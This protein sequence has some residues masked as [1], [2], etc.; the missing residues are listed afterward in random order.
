MNRFLLLLAALFAV[1]AVAH[2]RVCEEDKDMKGYYLSCK[3]D[4]TREMIWY[5]DDREC[6]SSGL[7]TRDRETGL[8]CNIDCAAGEYLPWAGTACQTCP[9]GSFSVGGGARFD[10]FDSWPHERSVIFRSWCARPSSYDD[11][12]NHEI[13]DGWRLSGYY[14]DSGDLKDYNSVSSVLVASF[15]LSE[16]DSYVRF[17]YSL[18]TEKGSDGL[19]I[20][21]DN[22]APREL[23]PTAE[24][25]EVTLYFTSGLHFVSWVYYKD[26]AGSFGED[27]AKLD[28]IEIYGLRLSD[29]E[30]TPCTPGFYGEHPGM[31]MCEE[32]SFNEF[33]SQH[34]STMCTACPDDQYALKG[35]F[36]CEDRTE[37]CEDDD[38]DF[39]YTECHQDASGNWVREKEAAWIQPDFCLHDGAVS[40][41]TSQTGLTCASCKPGYH[42][43]GAEGT[44]ELCPVGH[45]A[46][47]EEICNACPEGT[48]AVPEVYYDEWDEWLPKWSTGCI[49]EDCNTDGWELYSEHIH[50]GHHQGQRVDVWA[51]L[52]VNIQSFGGAVEFTYKLEGGSRY[53]FLQFLIDGYYG[54]IIRQMSETFYTERFELE[55]G[56]HELVWNFHRLDNAN[57]YPDARAYLQKVVVYGME[58]GGAGDCTTCPAGFYQDQPEQPE[59]KACAPGSANSDEGSTSCKKCSGREFARSDG[60]K[61]CLPCGVG[62][63]PN[64][65]HSDCVTD[66]VFMNKEKDVFDL[67]ALSNIHTVTGLRND[68][69]FIFDFCGRLPN[70]KCG[71]TNPYVC[72]EREV[73]T[74]RGEVLDFQYDSGSFLEFRSAEKS[75]YAFELAYTN[76][77]YEDC[78]VEVDRETLIKFKCNT[79]NT[80]STI[81]ILPKESDHCKN[82]F[83]VLSPY[84]C[85]VCTIDDFDR[86]E[87]SCSGGSRTVSFTKKSDAICYGS[88]QDDIEETCADVELS[89]APVIIITVSVV[90]LMAGIVI[91]LV[92]VCRKKRQLEHKYSMLVTNS[93]SGTEMTDVEGME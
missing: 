5:W 78:P 18:D 28:F 55:E 77:T 75:E 26:E 93:S 64:D 39:L 29:D 6:D 84:A 43:K 14:M 11:M 67:T 80:Q 62:T 3:D 9:A 12:G 47:G 38:Y 37:A 85:R 86:S 7:P 50:T 91:V 2:A 8:P 90:V 13:C 17:K 71:A 46:S 74:A 19:W 65:D 79:E 44:C 89:W 82:V 35:R 60:S 70:K 21:I 30:C 45:E 36:E 33:S 49:G 88:H 23:A 4:G 22:E 15:V 48:A 51:Q 40:L 41:P 52:D 76:G 68:S 16:D 61:Q 54:K 73:V 42:S 83:E 31:D 1:S 92:Y 58:G 20:Q 10:H 56:A 32:C 81:G 63:E 59:C 27:M 53:S 34:G 57:E 69:T 87:G 72:E 66:C 25:K 24:F